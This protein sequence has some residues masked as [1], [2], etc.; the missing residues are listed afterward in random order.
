MEQKQNSGAIFKNDKKTAENQPDYRG[1]INVD[2]REWEISLWVKEGQKAGKY[3][4][5]AI[6]EPWVKPD[7]VYQAPAK[8]VQTNLMNETDDDGLP[9]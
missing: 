1:K 7:E 3:F 4:S 8:P 5:A 6:K 9:F 2:G